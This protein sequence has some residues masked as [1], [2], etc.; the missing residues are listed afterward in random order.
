MEILLAKVSLK[1][2]FLKTKMQKQ[3]GWNDKVIRTKITLGQFRQLNLRDGNLWLDNLP[4]VFF[5]EK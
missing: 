1:L 2:N 5:M 3:F 4:K